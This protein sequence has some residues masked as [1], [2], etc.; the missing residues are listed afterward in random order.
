MCFIFQWNKFP[1][2]AV[3]NSQRHEIATD[4]ISERNKYVGFARLQRLYMTGAWRCR[5][6]TYLAI[7]S[8]ATRSRACQ[9]KSKV[10][11]ERVIKFW[12]KFTK[13][14]PNTISCW[15]CRGYIRSH[16][17]SNS[18]HAQLN[19][20]TSACDYNIRATYINQHLACGSSSAKLRELFLHYPNAFSTLYNFT[21]DSDFIE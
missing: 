11:G 16:G 21:D 19:Y 5:F 15:L 10:A 2:F 1:P 8:A 3:Y 20:K 9:H 14:K 12:L 7:G 6:I 18:T 4:F 17:P 13:N